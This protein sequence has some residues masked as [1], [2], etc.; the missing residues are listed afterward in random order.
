MPVQ[1]SRHH[2]LILVPVSY[3]R[4][5]SPEDGSCA[6]AVAGH[7]RV[8]A[9]LMPYP[10]AI[11]TLIP[12]SVLRGIR[13]RSICTTHE[14]RPGKPILSPLAIYDSASL[15]TSAGHRDRVVFRAT[16]KKREET[17]LGTAM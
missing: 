6:R 13:L 4:R 15:A 17:R 1:Q 16:H 8:H 10:T 3:L 9:Y 12:R 11:P 7:T 5:F 2:R 14:L